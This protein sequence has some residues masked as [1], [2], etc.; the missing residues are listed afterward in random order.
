[1]LNFGAAA[2]K[3]NVYYISKKY[4]ESY[5]VAQ[6]ELKLIFKTNTLRN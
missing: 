3:I 6:V 1:M 2:T 5:V 4:V